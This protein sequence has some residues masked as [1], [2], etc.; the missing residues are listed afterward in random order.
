MNVRSV[1]ERPTRP[2]GSHP[3]LPAPDAPD[4]SA[5]GASDRPDEDRLAVRSQPLV[6]WRVLGRRAFGWWRRSIRARVI[7]TT[8]VL[9]AVVIAALGIVLYHQVGAGL[10]RDKQRAALSEFDDALRDAQLQISQADRTDPDSFDSLLEQITTRLA[11]RGG[12]AE[13]EVAVLPG[14]GTGIGYASPPDVRPEDIPARLR[15]QVAAGT[16]ADAY[17]R[18]ERDG[19]STPAF[20][21]GAPLSTPT[22][23]FQLYYLFPLSAEQETLNLVQGTLEAGGAVLLVLLTAIVAVVTRLVVTPVRVAARA[24]ERLAA[25]HL[26]ERMQVR[27]EDEFARLATSFNEMAEALQRQILRLEELSRVQRRFTADVSHELRTP[28]TTVRMAGDVIYE[29][30]AGFPRAVA[31][32]AELLQTELDRFESLLVDLLEISRHDAGAAVLEAEPVDVTLLVRTAAAEASVH[33]GNVGCCL[34]LS[35][36]PD[37]EVEADADPR[38][39]A[40]ILRNLVHN[41]IEHSEGR[42][43]EL[44]LAADDDTVAVLVRD[45]GVGLRPG[46]EERVFERFWRADA[47]RARTTGGT[48]LGLS[49]AQ[50]DAR[51]HGGRI[52]AYGKPGL[53]A[54]FR[55]VLPRRAGRSPGRPPLP[56]WP[57]SERAAAPRGGGP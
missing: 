38:R 37:Q 39:L 42:D 5:P 21:V 15:A 25:G 10:L 24:S 32:S 53:G 7:V 34:D 52:D 36:V 2:S 51:L 27:G 30:R 44:A 41:A 17:T 49:I 54:A 9:S 43:I 55:L 46:D 18:I 56:L 31:R 26:Q 13:Y 4:A 23:G 29:A 28:L 33:A 6:R 20:V 35:R 45:H 3:A 12:S 50:E 16:Q 8:F 1:Q 14:T 11:A 57:P 40:R 47:A 19:R 22:G 48:G